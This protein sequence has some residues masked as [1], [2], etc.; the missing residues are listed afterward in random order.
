MT[1]TCGYKILEMISS[2]SPLHSSVSLNVS[3]IELQHFRL[4]HCHFPD[5]WNACC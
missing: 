3:V 2:V 4:Q 1:F 5:F